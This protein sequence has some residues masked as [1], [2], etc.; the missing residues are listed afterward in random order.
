M[1]VGLSAVNT[2]NAILN[3]FRGTTFTGVSTP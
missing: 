3:I 2:A 1:A